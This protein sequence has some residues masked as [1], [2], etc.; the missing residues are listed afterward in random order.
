MFQ[1]F[2]LSFEFILL[3]G[4]LTKLINF[5]KSKIRTRRMKQVSVIILNFNSSDFT[6]NCVK[7]ILEKTDYKIDYEIIIVDNGSTSED[8]FKLLSEIKQNDTVKIV[9][10]EINLGFSGGNMLGCNSCDS[11]YY[12]FLNNDCVL[13]NDVLSELYNFMESSPDAGICTGQMYN[14][15]MSKHSPFGYLPTLRLK[16][17]GSKLLRKFNPEKYLHRDINI[18]EPLNVQRITGAAMFADA[19]KFNAIGGFDTNYFLYCEEEDICNSLKKA[20]YQSY[21]VPAAKFIHFGGKSTGKS[22]AIEREFYISQMYYHRK[23]SN[24]FVYSLFKIYY[25]LKLGFGAFKTF[26]NLKLALFV[27]SGA[28]KRYSIRH[29]TS[30][31]RN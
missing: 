26:R 5:V 27:Q 23:H 25:V 7:S 10:S 21:V 6:I 9:K 8:Y 24:Y 15:D 17:F 30:K 28:P 18:V 11:K 22:Y 12:F 29:K 19:A 1:N 16:L 4:F 2:S 13:L 31:S 20:G 14:S 3:D